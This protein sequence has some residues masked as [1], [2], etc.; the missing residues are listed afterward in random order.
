MLIAHHIP[1]IYGLVEEALLGAIER[2]AAGFGAGGALAL[3]LVCLVLAAEAL[4]P[5]VER[6]AEAVR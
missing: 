4:T 5:T 1:D 3:V 6:R 2:A